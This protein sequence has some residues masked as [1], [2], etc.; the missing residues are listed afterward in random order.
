MAEHPMQPIEYD[1]SGVLRF[2]SNAIVRYL[3]DRGV[4]LNQLAVIGFPEEDWRQFAQL[5]GYSVDGYGE[6]SYVDDDSFAAAEARATVEQAQM[7]IEG[8]RKALLE[9][10]RGS[11]ERSEKKSSS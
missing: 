6:L 2:R 8:L 5:I 4:D 10:L 7:Q 1:E 3:L 11:D 9:I